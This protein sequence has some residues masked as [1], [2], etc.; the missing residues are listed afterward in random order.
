[1][2]RMVVAKV[3]PGRARGPRPATDAERAITND[4]PEGVTTRLVMLSVTSKRR[5]A[6]LLFW[7]PAHFIMEQ[8]MMRTIKA[9][10][11][12]DARHQHPPQRPGAAVA[13]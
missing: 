10:A 11:E 9:P 1:M 5:I 3:I 12:R 2:A 4:V 8:K 7:E 13:P 6:D